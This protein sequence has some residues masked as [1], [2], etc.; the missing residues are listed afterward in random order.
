MQRDKKTNWFGKHKVLT[1]L[2]ILV[3]IIIIASIENGGKSNTP[4]TNASTTTTNT[5]SNQPAQTATQSQ[6]PA[7]RQVKGTAATLGAGTFTV[8][9]DVQQGI[10]DVTP[11]AGQSGNFIV[12][13]SDGTATYNE[14]LGA[15]SDN[16]VSKV[17]TALVSGEQVQISGLSSVTF[18]PVTAPF[19]TAHATTTLYSGTFAVGQDIGSGR[20][21]ATPASGESGNFM[22]DDS[23]GTNKT[24]E[25]LGGDSSTGGV[26]SVSVTL[27]AGDIIT[28]SGVDRVTLTAQ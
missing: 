2:G 13:G 26:P 18:T 10:Y 19:V 22:V 21:I 11:G 7:Q 17:R 25:I 8:G 16:D 27:N 6:A 15:P 1:G 20:Y 28:I 5:S 9:K 24:N 12:T 4:T 14:V 3:A 23:N